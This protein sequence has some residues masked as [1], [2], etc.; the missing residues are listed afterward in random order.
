LNTK[1]KGKKKGEEMNTKKSIE[2]LEIEEV[3]RQV[4]RT[5]REMQHFKQCTDTSIETIWFVIIIIWVMISFII[6]WIFMTA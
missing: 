3:S 6:L 2:R 1:R 4:N 5:K